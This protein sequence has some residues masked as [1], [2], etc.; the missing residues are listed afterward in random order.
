VSAE[1]TAWS[2]L[3]AAGVMRQ[4]GLEVFR[5]QTDLEGMI[6]LPMVLEARYR[7]PAVKPLIIEKQDISP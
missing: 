7:Q 1:Q 4:G 2:K 5:V 6:R 3:Q